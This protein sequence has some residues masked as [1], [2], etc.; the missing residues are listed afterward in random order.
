MSQSK[1]K[2][3]RAN[4]KRSATVKKRLRRKAILKVIAE[5]EPIKHKTLVEKLL[6]IKTI[7]TGNKYFSLSGIPLDLEV[8]V[9]EGKIEKF[10][11]FDDTRSVIYKL[12]TLSPVF[13][14]KIIE[15]ES[16]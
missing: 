4:M 10:I 13:E 3:H 7:Q 16:I 11:D 12:A 6:E 9:N 14:S 15:E 1:I 2:K 5:N 8:L